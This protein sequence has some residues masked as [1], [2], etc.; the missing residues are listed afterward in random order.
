MDWE[1]DSFSIGGNGQL[2]FDDDCDFA[3]EHEENPCRTTSNSLHLPSSL[4]QTAQAAQ[5]KIR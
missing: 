4:R 3:W 2:G 5:Q 1:D